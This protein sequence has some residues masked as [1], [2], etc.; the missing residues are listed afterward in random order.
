VQHDRGDGQSPDQGSLG[1]LHVS[2]CFEQRSAES[3]WT[4]YTIV[5]VFVLLVIYYFARAKKSFKGL[6][7]YT[8]GLNKANNIQ[9]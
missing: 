2:A 6:G 5:G 1:D 8:N 4:G 3:S 9:A 7:F